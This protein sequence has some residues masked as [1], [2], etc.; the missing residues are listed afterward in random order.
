[1]WWV[2]VRVGCGLGRPAQLTPRAVSVVWRLWGIG[3]GDDSRVGL[4]VASCPCSVSGCPPSLHALVAFNCSA[5]CLHVAAMC[6]DWDAL[7]DDF[8]ALNFLPKNS[9]RC[10]AAG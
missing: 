10:E 8:I 3:A 2:P 6:R 9:D 5:A 4:I 1:M 7:V